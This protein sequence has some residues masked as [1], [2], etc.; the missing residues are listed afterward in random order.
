MC[1][2]MYFITAMGCLGR[3]AVFS[4]DMKFYLKLKNSLQNVEEKKWVGKLWWQR[5]HF[6]K[7]DWEN[8]KHRSIL[9]PIKAQRSSCG[10]KLHKTHH[11]NSGVE[12]AFKEKIEMKR[13][14][15]SARW[16][17]ALAR[18]AQGTWISAD[19]QGQDG[20]LMKAL[21]WQIT[22]KHW[23]DLKPTPCYLNFKKEGGLLHVRR[24]GK[25]KAILWDAMRNCSDF[26]KHFNFL[27]Q[28]GNG[29]VLC[30][31]C[32]CTV[33]PTS[34]Q[35]E[36]SCVMLSWALVNMNLVGKRCRTVKGLC[37]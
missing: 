16:L 36:F 10:Y 5:W 11:L 20:N 37:S 19:R 23:R 24:K 15:S 12:N 25:G 2:Y 31:S 35:G 32:G 29:A 28:T 34:L 27:M 1:H 8:G 7:V 22:T 9:Q 3:A 30:W 33:C 6:R 18:N 14:D 21:K 26:R 4:P 17:Q 13:I